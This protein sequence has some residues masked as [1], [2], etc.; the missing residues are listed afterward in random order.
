[1]ASEP[2][3]AVQFMLELAAAM[4]LAGEAVAMNQA[5][6]QRIAAAYHVRDARVA[7]LP[8]LVLG[9]GGR[10]QPTAFE[11]ARVQ[12][13]GL[14]LDRTAAVAEL[15]RAAERAEVEPVAGL[16]RLHAIARIPHRFGLAGVIGGHMV[17][18]IGLA[19]ILQP[20]PEA[21]GLSAVFGALVG[22]L[23]AYARNMQT[24]GV[25][26]PV[27]AATLVSALAF[28]FAPEKT[29]EGSMRVLIPC[30]VTFLPGGLLTTATLDLSAGEVISGASQLVAGTMQLLL[31]S[32]GIAA[33]AQL[34]GV[35]LDVAITNEAKNTLGDW[36]PWLGVV[37]F[38]VGAFVHFSGPPR[39][40]GWLLVVL[41]AAWI[42]QQ[43]GGHATSDALGGFFGGL[44]VIPV[45][46][47]VATR[48]S[49]PPALATFLPAF[50][51]LVPGAV[52][53]IGVAEFVGS[54]RAAGLDHFV[55][56]G[57]TFTAIGLGVLVGNAL[58][59]RVS[60]ARRGV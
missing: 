59:L 18:T 37:V 29:I 30:L 48:R 15:A 12:P 24:V 55:N 10:G 17:L 50:W 52:G 38:G 45:A 16:H 5:R 27:T 28:E 11:L 1:M 20:T 53:L 57:I 36:A 14:R 25:L 42:G 3:P 32:F 60:A 43:L 54:N 49:G 2:E 6:T 23:K 8:N 58:V 31:L 46:S 13:L 34:A 26:L 47:W 4:N 7:V 39:T 40:L 22:A 9:A 56:A 41:F 19:L 44:V 21:L 33:G 51:L 35:S